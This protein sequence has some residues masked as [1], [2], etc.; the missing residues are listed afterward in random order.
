MFGIKGIDSHLDRLEAV[1]DRQVPISSVESLYAAIDSK[2]TN[3]LRLESIAFGFDTS[4]IIKIAT[5]K[6]REDIIDYLS[7][8]H[9]GPLILPGQAVQEFWNNQHAGI[10]TLSREIKKK[11]DMLKK[12]VEK[13][14]VGF[15]SFVNDMDDLM[16]K[17]DEEYGYIFDPATKNNVLNFIEMLKNKARLTYVPRSRFQNMALNRKQT[18]TPPGFK[19]EGNGDFFIWVEFLFGLL[20]AKG[21]GESFEHAILLTGDQKIDWSVE[22]NAHPIL[23]SEVQALVGIP[24]EL[25]TH[26]QLSKAIADF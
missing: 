6:K 24:F 20:L 15:G 9:V 14:D 12:E 16:T 17:F 25:W 4:A 13:M 10:S 21:N 2:P 7:A 3:D 22:G 18:K 26:D 8:R 5:S 11:F 23:V 19:D 1:L